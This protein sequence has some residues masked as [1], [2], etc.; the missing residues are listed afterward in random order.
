MSIATFV[1]SSSLWWASYGFYQRRLWQMLDSWK[2]GAAEGQHGT[3]AAVQA[4]AAMSAGTWSRPLSCGCLT[5]AVCVPCLARCS[6]MLHASPQCCRLHCGAADQPPRRH[7]DT[8]ANCQG[9][10]CL[11]AC[12]VDLCGCTR[13]L[14]SLDVIG[15]PPQN[16]TASTKTPPPRIQAQAGSQPTVRNVVRELVEQEGLGGFLRGVVPRMTASAMWGTVMLSVYELLKR[17]C[18]K[19]ADDAQQ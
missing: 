13:S 1:P 14:S 18:A 17:I 9:S 10:L 11:D 12:N 16:N 7:Q 2:V 3:V 6:S 19:H 8:T 4:A 5:L 15:T